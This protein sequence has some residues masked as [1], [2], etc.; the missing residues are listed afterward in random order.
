MDKDTVE[1]VASRRD[2]CVFW[3]TCVRVPLPFWIQSING[4]G[5]CTG[6][7]ARQIIADYWSTQSQHTGW[8]KQHHAHVRT[9]K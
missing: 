2:T 6:L 1:F 4:H 8:M 5:T 7:G 3:S 9:Y